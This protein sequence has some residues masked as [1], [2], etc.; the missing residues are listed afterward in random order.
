MS[1]NLQE[2][3]VLVDLPIRTIRYYIQ[4]G[5]VDRPLGARKSATYG[6]E[7]VEQL[8]QIKKWQAAGLSLERIAQI[9]SNDV[10]ELPPAPIEVPGSIKL[11][12]KVHLAPGLKLEIDP[13]QVTF[14]TEQIRILARKILEAVESIKEKDQ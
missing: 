9:L 7:H 2:L 12:S 14:T 10:S 11:C 8:L 5:M 3:S 4:K 6:Q 1:H 13:G